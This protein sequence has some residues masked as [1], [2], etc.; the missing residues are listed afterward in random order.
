MMFRAP[1]WNRLPLP[2]CAHG[3]CCGLA[4]A[5]GLGLLVVGHPW[6]DGCSR[7]LDPLD[8]FGFATPVVVDTAGLRG[9]GLPEV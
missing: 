2:C 3:Y 8:F 5:Q 4:E 9:Y 6:G 1:L 7:L